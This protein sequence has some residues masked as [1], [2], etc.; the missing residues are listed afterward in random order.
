MLNVIA[1]QGFPSGIVVKN[2]I[3]NAGDASSI[4]GPGRSPEVGNGNPFQYSC[5]DNFTDR[6]AW[7]ATARGSAE[8]CTQLSAYTDT[9]IQGYT[10]THQML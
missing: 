5:L 6:G 3:A 2:P 9:H 1:K 8:S 4:P 7:Q 10:D